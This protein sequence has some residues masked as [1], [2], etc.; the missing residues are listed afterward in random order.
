VKRLGILALLFLLIGILIV[1]VVVSRKEAPRIP[2]K[3]I[4]HVTVRQ[5]SFK[6]AD[7]LSGWDEKVLTRYRTDY[8]LAEYK[9]ERCVK[10]ESK[11]SASSLY[12]KEPLSHLKRPFVSWDWT[13]EK[14]PERKQEETLDDKKE[15][16]F[17]AQVY[18]I[19]ESRF[20]LMTK[21]IQYVWTEKVPV[22][23]VS[24]SPYTK[25][26]KI[27]VLESGP[28]DEWKHEV[29][30]VKEDFR[31]LFGKKMT[32]DVEAFAFMTDSDSTGSSATAYY[33]N[34]SLGYI[35]PVNE[36]RSHQE[37]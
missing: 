35:E 8:N 29:R 24:D 10:A 1:G 25:N 34:I 2:S 17:G 6:T 19:F 7:S 11:N 15:F 13:V 37:H 32:K 3:D 27:M 18:V 26:V 9:G 28:S 5:L 4:K 14:F 21:A 16:D 36:R 12:V 30:D 31:A 22:G 23:T 20:F 33:S